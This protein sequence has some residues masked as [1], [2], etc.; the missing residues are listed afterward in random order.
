MLKNIKIP[1]IILI[2]LM[3]LCTSSC[4]NKKDSDILVHNVKAL[5][6][7]NT[8]IARVD[9]EGLNI[10]GLSIANN[11]NDY[12]LGSLSFGE[13]DNGDIAGIR[14]LDV[15]G[16][17]Y[18]GFEMIVKK[19]E[20]VIYPFWAI[21]YSRSGKQFY[22]DALENGL[23]DDYYNSLPFT[24]SDAMSFGYTNEGDRS[25]LYVSLLY[26]LEPISVSDV[27]CQGIYPNATYKC[28]SSSVVS[29]IA[30]NCITIDDALAFVGAVDEDYKEIVSSIPPQLN[31]YST[32]TNINGIDV[33]ILGACALED[34]SGR[35]GILEFINNKAIWHEGNNYSFNYFIQNDFLYNEDGTYKEILGKGFGR[36]NSTVLYLDDIHNMED[37]F[38]LMN[39]VDYSN[40]FSQNSDVDLRSEFCDFDV[41]KRYEEY[42]NMGLN[43]EQADELYPLYAYYLDSETE[44]EVLIDSYEKWKDNNDHLD[45]IYNL[46]YCLN[47]E[48]NNE[49][50]NLISWFKIF[51]NGL[52]NEEKKLIGYDY[53]TY[54]KVIGDPM[55][56]RVTR[57]FNEEVSTSN[58]INF[59]DVCDYTYIKEDK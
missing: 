47:D 18:C 7:N 38:R 15:S 26:R 48:N 51:Y 17:D 10:N 50:S 19:G 30:A 3:L 58:T 34:S 52:S 53:I 12:N 36:S 20:N 29:L 11:N 32:S 27:I 31:V 40:M 25:S 41:F 39:N 37:H 2:I 4:Q 21:A 6:E 8:Y 57:Y 22:Y 59:S 54:I 24:A 35:H 23:D 9:Y 46:E 13:Y 49:L 16:D 45:N 14:N 28:S 43:T 5:Y 33:N 1:T 55:N 44:K 42:K 56:Y